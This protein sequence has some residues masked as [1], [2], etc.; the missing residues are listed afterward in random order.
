[1][2]QPSQM[3]MDEGKRPT[4]AAN[5]D[6]LG[7]ASLDQRHV[8]GGRNAVCYDGVRPRAGVA[9]FDMPVLRTFG[10]EARS[11]RVFRSVSGILRR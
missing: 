3:M 2:P 10:V 8:L 4:A 5:C 6:W 7:P 1:V 9:I 11:S